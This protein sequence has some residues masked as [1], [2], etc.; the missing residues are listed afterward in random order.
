VSTLESVAAAL[1]LCGE[2]P[3]IEKPDCRACFARLVQRVRDAQVIPPKPRRS[4]PKQRRAP[5]PRTTG[6]ELA[7]Q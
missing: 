5:D 2:A 6:L 7:N 3:E 4:P 1:T